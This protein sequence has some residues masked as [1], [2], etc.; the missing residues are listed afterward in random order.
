MQSVTLWYKRASHALDGV[1]H[2]STKSYTLT[3]RE[4]ADIVF[5]Q[6]ASTENGT[7][8]PDEEEDFI[9]DIMYAYDT[10]R[11]YAIF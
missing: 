6:Y 4:S 8:F 11:L 3:F 5:R 1:P 9:G 2:R 10:E 7:Q